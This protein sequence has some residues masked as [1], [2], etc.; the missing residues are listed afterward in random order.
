V[1]SDYNFLAYGRFHRNGQ[2]II[3]INNNNAPLTK[4]LNVW[5]IGTPKTGRMKNL[6]CSEQN[7]YTLEERKYEVKAGKITLEMPPTSAM[8]LKFEREEA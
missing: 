1:D 3:L 2:C 6:L 5:E 4:E 8:I 7:G